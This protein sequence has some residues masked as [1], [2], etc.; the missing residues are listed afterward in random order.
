MRH[1]GVAWLGCRRA[2][3]AA[4]LDL[5]ARRSRPASPAQH[6][7]GRQR[8]LGGRGALGIATRLLRARCVARSACARAAGAGRARL[9]AGWHGVERTVGGE[10]EWEREK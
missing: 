5:Q 2:R 7:A 9:A 4:R 8:V 3:E 1:R 6:R 10:S